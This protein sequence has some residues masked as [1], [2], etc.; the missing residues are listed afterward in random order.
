MAVQVNGVWHS[1][2]D[3]CLDDYKAWYAACPEMCGS[4][5]APRL[6]DVISHFGPDGSVFNVKIVA[7]TPVYRKPTTDPAAV[8]A[9]GALRMGQ[10]VE[11]IEDSVAP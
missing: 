9:L 7:L 1:S 4:P 3:L 11:W 8:V 6:D 2:V 5:G 10:R